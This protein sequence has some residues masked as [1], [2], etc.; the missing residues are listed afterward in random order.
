MAKQRYFLQLS[1]DGTNYHGWQRQPNVISVQE[2]LE[3]ALAKVLKHPVALIGCGRTDA[4][5]HARAYIAHIDVAHELEVDFLSKLNFTL[6]DD[7]GV[8]RVWPVARGLHAQFSALQRTY[9]YHV[10]T[11]KN[12]FQARFSTYLPVP[13]TELDWDAMQG[14]A[15]LL[16]EHTEYRGCCKVPDRHDSTI[17]QVTAA[18][19]I[20]TADDAFYFSITANRFLRGMVRLL[21]AQL[22]D[23]GQ[24]REAVE[25]F[26][27]RLER[28]ERPKRFVY[29]AAQG[30]SLDSVRY[31]EL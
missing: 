25:D 19:F 7:I 23:I 18:T 17:C 29:A 16:L 11:R 28:A 10:H 1:Y 3:Q 15:Q 20:R 12:P 9:H 8:Q 21:T 6:P 2:A 5:V 24:S 13:L 30:L 14:A 31:P 22:L 26:S 27:Q 4:G